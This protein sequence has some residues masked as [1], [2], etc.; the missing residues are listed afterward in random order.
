MTEEPPTTLLWARFYMAQHLD[1]MKQHQ[2]ALDLVEKSLEHTP[3]LIELHA[4]KAK[5]LKVCSK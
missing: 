5:I 4:L 3:T 1:A 2:Q